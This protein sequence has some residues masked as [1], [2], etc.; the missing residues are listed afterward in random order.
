MW[1]LRS[2]RDAFAVPASSAKK[3]AACVFVSFVSIRTPVPSPESSS[4]AGTTAESIRTEPLLE[5]DR[6]PSQSGELTERHPA[7]DPRSMT[8]QMRPDRE[9]NLYVSRGTGMFSCAVQV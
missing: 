1:R 8:A 5:I 9:S 2:S 6:T 3:R 4:S 7:D